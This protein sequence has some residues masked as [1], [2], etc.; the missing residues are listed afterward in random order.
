MEREGK[1]I[2]VSA[3]TIEEAI[4]K[5][6]VELGKAQDEVEIEVLSPGS[7]GV[8]GIGA[9][10]AVVRLSFVEPEKA[11]SLEEGVEQI[12]KET[13]Q[14]LLTKMGVRAQVSI[15]PDEEMH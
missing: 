14:E 6:L 9:K 7:R 2:E 3:P 8:L 13:L 4:A 1:H 15:R 12:A 11:P 10:D 5:G